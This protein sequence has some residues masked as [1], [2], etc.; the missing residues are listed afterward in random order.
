[1]NVID[2]ETRKIDTAM[3]RILLAEDHIILREG[4]KAVL[5]DQPGIQIVAEANNGKEVQKLLIEHEVDV[6]ILDINMPEMD[7]IQTA[8]YIKEN[9]KDTKV[10]MLSMLDNENYV[11]KSFK[12]GALGYV[13]KTT[14]SDEF[15]AAIKQVAEGNPYISHKIAADIVRKM[16]FHSPSLNNIQVDLSK[17]EIE[18]LSLIAEGFTNGEIA[19]KTFTSKRTVETH[20]KNLI[21]KTGTKNTASLIKFAIVNGILR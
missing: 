3:T 21:E 16:N 5:K 2:Q 1:M 4:L 18:I 9:F 11:S 17:R 6:A 15:V 14:K 10:L 7:G 20:R 19:D 13:L 8:E 12:A